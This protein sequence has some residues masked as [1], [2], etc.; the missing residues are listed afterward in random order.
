M[1]AIYKKHQS[2]ID[3]YLNL[4]LKWNKT[5]NLTAITNWQDM[6]EKHIFDSLAISP[7]LAGES[8][9]D[10]GSG[11][12]FPGIPLAISNPDRRFYLLDSR[13]KKCAFLTAVKHE[14]KLTNLT[15]INARLE[16]YACDFKF[17]TI[18]SRAFCSLEK[19]I[20][21]SSPLLKS[22]GTLLAMKGKT[23]H[24]ELEQVLFPYI[25]KFYKIAQFDYCCVIIKKDEDGKNNS[26]N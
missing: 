22:Q 15:V 21:L 26:H 13:G 20:K 8:C 18:T 23:F 7:Y 14:L 11:A 9:L 19:F 10:A 17:D 24:H 3:N 2:T 6:L 25:L 16:N 12:G 4:L 5:Y 1:N